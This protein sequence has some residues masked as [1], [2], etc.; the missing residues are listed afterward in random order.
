MDITADLLSTL[1]DPEVRTLCWKLLNQTEPRDG[2]IYCPK[3][4][5]HVTCW[6]YT[7]ANVTATG[8]CPK[9]H[10]QGQIF[11]PQGHS[12]RQC[13]GDGT[14]YVSPF[15]N[16]SWTNYIPCADFSEYQNLQNINYVYESGYV[17]SFI[18]LCLAL[19]IFTCFRQLHCTRVTIHKNLFLSY[20]L[21]GLMWL[22]FNYLVTPNPDVAF[23]T[24]IWC[25]ALWILQKYFQ[26]CNYAW[27]FA[28]GFYL[29]SIIVLTFT[30]QK[31]L[32]LVALC[33]GWVIPILPVSIYAILNA[34]SEDPVGRLHCWTGDSGENQLI[35][36][37]HGT[38]MASLVV[39]LSILVNVM[40]IVVMKIRA[41]N[42]GETT[43]LRKTL[44]AC[45][46]LVPLLG[47]QQVLFPF[48]SNHIAYRVT[49]ALV[50]SY[51]GAC[52]AL[53]LC[54]FNREVVK[55]F[56]KKISQI[57]YINEGR[58]SS[59]LT[60]GTSLGGLLRRGSRQISIYTRRTSESRDRKTSENVPETGNQIQKDV[61]Q[62]LLNEGEMKESQTV[63]SLLSVG[64]AVSLTGNSTRRESIRSG[65][66][67]R[68]RCNLPSIS[69]V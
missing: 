21:Y 40:R 61:N 49:V 62:P 35:W 52:V 9:S 45:L 34:K 60:I 18:L 24:P 31:K 22:L 56:K 43:Q 17:V 58:R 6:N 12:Y 15:N 8:G 29:H 14:W 33:I 11:S 38:C 13:M 68:G 67:S 16:M 7:L 63:E 26:I 23:E 46:I 10:P 25:V 54:F 53:L 5:D 59:L 19:I 39:N 44:R 3:V 42:I 69:E 30:N 65:D 41:V 20:I 32:L 27:L 47:L 51:Q 57:K 55:C 2:K 64:D 48:Q 4:F 28:E 66:S 37:L 50:S 1:V 36:I